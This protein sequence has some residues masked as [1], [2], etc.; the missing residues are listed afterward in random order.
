MYLLEQNT[1][2]L[3]NKNKLT[4]EGPVFPLEETIEIDLKKMQCKKKQK[5]IGQNME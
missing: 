4:Q 5:A 1:F 2:R 3:E